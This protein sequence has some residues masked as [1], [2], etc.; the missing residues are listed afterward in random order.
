MIATFFD[1]LVDGLR[2]EEVMQYLSTRDVCVTVTYR[3]S[4]KSRFSVGCKSP[5]WSFLCA[6]H[7]ALK[8]TKGCG[9]DTQSP[10]FPP[11]PPLTNADWADLG[12]VNITST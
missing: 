4:D 11:T 3:M 6:N 7:R 8:S 2:G 12:A 5:L 9:P 10:Q 1:M